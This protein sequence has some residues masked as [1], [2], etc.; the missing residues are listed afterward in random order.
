MGDDV[1]WVRIRYMD[2]GGIGGR[3]IRCKSWGK[4][5]E[6]PDTYTLARRYII[7]YTLY[8]YYYMLYRLATDIQRK[9][10]F[11]FSSIII[12]FFSPTSLREKIK[13]KLKKILPR[14]QKMYKLGIS[15]IDIDQR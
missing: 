10:A 8:I 15:S 6:I 12:F 9:Q 2:D 11:Q 5:K 4:K 1:L 14:R 7:I 13:I 3:V